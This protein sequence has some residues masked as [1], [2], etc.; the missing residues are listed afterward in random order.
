VEEVLAVAAGLLD[1]DFDS[2]FDSVLAVESL[3]A[4]VLLDDVDF[5][6]FAR[7]SVR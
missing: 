1:S 6:P 2:V 5:E 4:E 7:L 3:A